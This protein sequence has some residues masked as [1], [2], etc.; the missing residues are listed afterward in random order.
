[1]HRLTRRRALAGGAVLAALMTRNATT[2]LADPASTGINAQIDDLERRNNVQIGVYALDLATGRSI[3]H[4]AAERF[5]M[6]SVFKTYAAASVMQKSASGELALTDTVMVQRDDVLPYSP[7][8][9]TRVGQSITLSELCAAALQRSDNTAANYLLRAVGGP[10]VITDFARSIGD[11]QTRLDRIEPELNSAIPGDLRDT[12]TPRAIGTGHLELITGL[13]LPPPQR[14]QLVDWLTTN[15]TSTVRPGMPPGW[16][17]ADRT[18]SGDYG[19]ANDVGVATGAGGR[20]VVLAV[21]TRTA[22]QDPEAADV[23]PLMPQIAA[24][25]MSYLIR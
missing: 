23:R 1:M 18:G 15:E 16:S 19:T 11:D 24:S 12:T 21:M 3:A 25:V 20:Q 14:G 8:T 10:P 22:T 2:A 5:A 13:A 9:E 6:C 17:L 4:R 7:I